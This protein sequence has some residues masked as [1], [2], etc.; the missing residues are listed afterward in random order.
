MPKHVVILC[1]PR[2]DSFNA[3]VAEGYCAA[4]REIGH[5]VVLRDLYRMGFDP[6]LKADEQPG[7]VNHSMSAD[8]AHELELLAGVSV[9]VLVYPIWFGTP[10]AMLKGYVERVLGSGFSHQAIRGRARHRLV[11]THMLSL[12]SSGT[13]KQWLEEQGAWMS[14]RVVFDLYLEKAFSLTSADHV[15]FSAVVTGLKDRYVRECLE[16]VRQA[17]RKVSSIVLS[18]HRRQTAARSHSATSH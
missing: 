8:V 12:T 10:P 1:H 7:S 6:V 15:H 11:G 16:E 9:L 13:T 3:T 14:L 4:V 2:S 18:E 17:A 5:E